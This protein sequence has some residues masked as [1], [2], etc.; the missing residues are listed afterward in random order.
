MTVRLPCTVIELWNYKLRHLRYDRQFQKY[1]SLKN[2]FFRKLPINIIKLNF[3]EWRRI[4]LYRCRY[5]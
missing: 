5:Y 2:T 1:F 4:C 3:S